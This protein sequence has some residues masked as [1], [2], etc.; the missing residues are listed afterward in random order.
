MG[1]YEDY[2]SAILEKP[3]RVNLGDAIQ[4]PLCGISAGLTSQSWAADTNA[5]VEAFLGLRLQDLGFRA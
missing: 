3:F 5:K 1:S 2:I 4:E